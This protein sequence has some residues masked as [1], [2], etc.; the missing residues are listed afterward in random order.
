MDRFLV[1]QDSID[2]TAHFD[3]LLPVP[4]VPGEA[5][6]LTCGYGADLSK[7]DFRHHAVKSSAGHTTGGRTTKVVIYR[8]DVRPSKRSQPVAHGAW[9]AL[10][11]RLCRT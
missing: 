11:S 2:N 4:T 8:L 7:A 3:E 9:R 10:L 1:D 6:Y 5:R